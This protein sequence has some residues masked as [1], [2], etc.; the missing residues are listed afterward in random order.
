MDYTTVYNKLNYQFKNKKLLI[1]AL[2]HSSAVVKDFLSSYE[3]LEFLGDSLL[4]FVVAEFL[5][6]KFP[7]KKEGELTYLR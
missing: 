2:T 5:Y 1:T 3:R 7:L 6:N 4:N